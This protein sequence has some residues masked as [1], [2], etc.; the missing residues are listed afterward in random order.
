MIQCIN[1]AMLRGISAMP[2]RVECDVSDGLPGFE[3]V[4]YLSS[5]VK[6]GGYRVKS[7]LKNAGYKLPAKKI[8]INFSPASVKKSGTSFDLPVLLGLAVSYG[9]VKKKYLA[10]AVVVGEVS[11]TGDILPVDGVLPIVGMAKQEGF[12]YCIVPKQ[13]EQEARLE[14]GIPI[15]GVANMLELFSILN[16]QKS[17]EE[18]PYC[19][20]TSQGGMQE[21]ISNDFLDIYGNAFGKRGILVAASGMHNILFIGTPGAGK[22]MLASRIPSILPELSFEETMEVTKIYSVSG[23]LKDHEPYIKTRPFRNPH[24]TTTASA[25]VGGGM[26]AK[27]GE[28][29]LAHRGVLFLDELPEF[30]TKTLE[31]LRQPLEEKQVHIARINGNYTYPANFMLVAAMNPCPC[32]YYPDFSKCNCTETAIK[33]YLGKISGPFMDRMDLCIQ[34]SEVKY[35]E[36]GKKKEGLSSAQMKEMVTRAHERQRERFLQEDIRYNAEMGA[37]HIERFCP[38]STELKEYM[39]GVYEKR[40]MSVR[41][42]HKTLKVARTIADLAGHEQIQREDLEEALL[43]KYL[44][45][46]YWGR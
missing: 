1:T 38:L 25:L 24:H 27:P 31:T 4:G 28:V 7:A 30:S 5:E 8:M 34:I 20:G 43:Y 32:G 2:I 10:K 37:E 46:S 13:N 41:G 36:F 15:I 29:S 14:K 42:Y 44:D 16:G 35:E 18:Y 40:R 33:R 26:K 45:E 3:M 6:E 17:P 11:L 12:S 23:L 19:E 9:F 21:A 39:K 22:S